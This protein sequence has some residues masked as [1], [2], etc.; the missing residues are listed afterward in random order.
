M[1]SGKTIAP[2]KHRQIDFRDLYP[3]LEKDFPRNP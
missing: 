3:E 2:F 1:K